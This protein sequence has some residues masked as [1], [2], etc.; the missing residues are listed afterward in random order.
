MFAD[1]PTC[2]IGQAGLI[3]G[4]SYRAAALKL[5][6]FERMGLV[7][8]VSIA[9]RHFDPPT[10]PLHVHEPGTR[11]DRGRCRDLSALFRCR[12]RRAKV[13]PLRMFVATGKALNVLGFGDVK[14]STPMTATH[15]ILATDAF[16]ANRHRG[17][18]RYEPQPPGGRRKFEKQPDAGIFGPNGTPEV[19]IEIAG[20]YRADRVESLLEFSNGAG[21]PLEFW[22]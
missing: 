18:W 15:D 8:S 21:I 4:L 3:W 22:Q 7:K 10:A 2:T 1:V 5:G 9:A 14:P 20:S 6:D 11:I 12:Y 19:F 16:I 17:I 13:V